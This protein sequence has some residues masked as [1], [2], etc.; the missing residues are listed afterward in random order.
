MF[1]LVCFYYVVLPPPLPN[2]FSIT[3]TYSTAVIAIKIVPKAMVSECS[4]L[5]LL[6]FVCLTDI[7]RHKITNNNPFPKP[8]QNSKSTP[9]ALLCPHAI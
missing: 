1:E 4:S 5:F 9:E 3:I 8:L 2:I 6:C 7:G